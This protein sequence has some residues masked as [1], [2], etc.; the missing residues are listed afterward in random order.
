MSKHRVKPVSSFFRFSPYLYKSLVA[1][2]RWALRHEHRFGLHQMPPKIPV[3]MRAAGGICCS[4]VSRGSH[5]RLPWAELA[6]YFHQL[7]I[8]LMENCAGA[9][10]YWHLSGSRSS[11]QLAPPTPSP[12]Y[13]VMEHL[14]LQKWSRNFLSEPQ[15]QSSPDCPDLLSIP[16]VLLVADESPSIS[17][18]KHILNIPLSCLCPYLWPE[19]EI[20]KLSP[21]ACGTSRAKLRNKISPLLLEVSTPSLPAWVQGSTALWCRSFIQ[22]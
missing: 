11:K 20:E 14:C 5:R 4:D 17:L 9:T 19:A 18:W 1:C 2:Q 10:K 21:L 15:S 3:E 7:K 13:Q 8:F 22:L 12:Q 16:L 6:R